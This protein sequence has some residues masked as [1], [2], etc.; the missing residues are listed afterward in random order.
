MV[1]KKISELTAIDP[2][3]GTES[4]AVVQGGTTKKA[5]A[6]EIATRASDALG[7]G[8]AATT[9]ADEYATAAQGGLADTALQPGDYAGLFVK[10]DTRQVAWTKTGNDT[11]ET[12]TALTIVVDGSVV[13]IASGTNISMPS[14]SA[15]TDY[16]IWVAPDGT[17]EADASFT[18]PPTA[19]GRRVGGFHYAPGGNATLD[20]AGDWANHTGGDTT[21]QINEYSFYDLKWRPSVADPRGLTLVNESFWAGMYLMSANTTVA[22]LHKFGVEPARDGNDPQ[23]PYG[24]GTTYGNAKPMNVFECLSYY[25]FR[26]P[27]VNEFQ[28]LAL[29]VNEERSIGGSGPGNTGDVTD[30]SKNEQTSA[31]GVF[32]ATGVLSVWGRDSLPDNDQDSGVTEGRSDNVFRISRFAIFG[33]NWRSGSY[34]GSRYVSSSSA[35]FS[36]TGFGGRGVCSHLILD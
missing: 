35:S 4:F 2:L 1:D 5:T 3:D 21:A 15:G 25:G 28:L 32:D 6:D 12:S 17:L 23:K 13:N 27:D 16:A 19:N 26:A 24:D 9:D 30:R 31:W 11:A 10:A 8:T 36:F 22:P 18:T 33:G 34:S 7:L 29:G 14:L 20:S